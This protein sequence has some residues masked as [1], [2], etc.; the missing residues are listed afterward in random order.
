MA[1]TNKEWRSHRHYQLD[2][3]SDEILPALLNSVDIKRY[4]D[5][6]CLIEKTTFDL[7][8]L[9]TASYEMRFL[10]KLYYWETTNDGRLKRRCC[11][12]SV[13]DTVTLPRNSITYLWMKEKLL[14]PEYIAARFNLHIRYVH[15]GLLLGTGPLVDPG[16]FGNLLIPL[17]NLTDNDYELKGGD[18]FIWLEFTKLS[19]HE[20]W[21]KHGIQRPHCLKSFPNRKGIDDPELYFNKSDL[22]KM[23]GVQSAFKG[24]LDRTQRHCK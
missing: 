20:F 15:K 13:G 5:R 24:T 21:S 3:L 18:G 16:F 8:R 17:H 23:G 22:T 1:M 19:K 14:L 9:K 11:D 12:V 4:V 6:D 7:E 10:G 2:P